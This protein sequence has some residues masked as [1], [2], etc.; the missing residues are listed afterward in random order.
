MAE[1][2]EKGITAKAIAIA[3]TM[4]KDGESIE[5]IIKWTGLK[6]EEIEKLRQAGALL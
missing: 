4:L 3:K 5:K 2:M 6:R 1:G